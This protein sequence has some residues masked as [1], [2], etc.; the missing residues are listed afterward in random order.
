M[1][2]EK[3]K[4]L[5][6][7]TR[8]AYSAAADRPQD[9]HPFPVGMQFAV[10]LGYPQELISSLPPIAS[11]AFSG[12]SNVALF[13]DL[14]ADSSVLD[15]GCGAGLDALIAAGRVGVDG[16]VIGIDFSRSMLRR[17]HQVAE[18]AGVKRISFCQADG[19]RL[20]LAEGAIDVAMVNGILNLNPKRGEIFK[21]L[22][23]VVRRGGRV[24]AAELIL[25]APLPPVIQRSEL[26]WFA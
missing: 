10:S 25:K 8:K 4:R 20:P 7:G 12:V 26:E 18:E 24:Y 14:P 5:R 11:E 15:L 17:A 9:E 22:A 1:D 21:E 6:E 19:E 2:R 13:A 23:R 3:A 16:R